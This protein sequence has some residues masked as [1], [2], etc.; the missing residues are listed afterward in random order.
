MSS[1]NVV[2]DLV[3]VKLSASWGHWP[4]RQ[5][6]GTIMHMQD[7]SKEQ[8]KG[9]YYLDKWQYSAYSDIKVMQGRWLP[10]SA[11]LESNVTAQLKAP[12]VDKHTSNQTEMDS[13]GHLRLV[14]SRDKTS[15]AHSLWT[16]DPSRTLFFLLNS[17]MCDLQYR[18]TCHWGSIPSE[19]RVDA[20][21][22]VSP[23]H[24]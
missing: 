5:R 21:A 12:M 15:A 24:S 16:N 22:L 7:L 20:N 23:Q 1:F 9:D 17:Q 4:I 13:L 3:L 18:I 11:S 10:I 6:L 2:Y 8:V 19:I 14:A